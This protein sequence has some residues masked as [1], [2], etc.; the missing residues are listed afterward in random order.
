MKKLLIIPFIMLMTVLA[1]GQDQEKPSTGPGR[2]HIGIHYSYLNAHMR[3]LS[4]TKHSVWAGEDL[5][6]RDLSAEDIDT[7]NTYMDYR[8]KLN[9]LSLEAGMVLLNK[10]EG[11]WYIDGVLQL[12]FMQ[13][14]NDVTN[15]DHD[16]A[17]MVITSEHGSP[18]IGLGFNFRYLFNDQWALNLGLNSMF[19]FSKADE[20]A[21]EIFP[22]ITFMEEARENHFRSSYSSMDLMASYKI[23]DFTVAAGP[24]FYFLHTWN[25]YHIIRTDVEDGSEYEDSIETTLRTAM[26]LNGSI[27]L[28]WRI[29]PHF[30]VTA[31]GGFGK[32]ISAN[33]GLVYFL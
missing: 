14:T 31:G 23:K 10:P 13:R 12:G 28:D 25:R 2:F 26:F 3:L 20:I 19:T 17:H 8:E 15:T 29:S 32:D 9:N 22:V 30:L 4:M 21:D 1:T 18:S 24:G 11:N 5:G 33:A 16:S 7:I 6:T 27:R